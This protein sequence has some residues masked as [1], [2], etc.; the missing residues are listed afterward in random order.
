MHGDPKIF[1]YCK[2]LKAKFYKT[3]HV[4][5]NDEGP[6]S[7]YI[8]PSMLASTFETKKPTIPYL[9]KI[10]AI[11]QDHGYGVYN[12]PTDKHILGELP[13]SPKSYGMPKFIPS[14]SHTFM[15]APT[16]FKRW[17]DLSQEDIEVDNASRWLYQED[18]PTPNLSL[19]D[20]SKGLQIMLKHGYN[21]NEKLGKNDNGLLEPFIP[22]MWPKYLGL[23]LTT[24][25]VTIRGQGTLVK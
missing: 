4:S 3:S 25:K 11:I 21:K 13:Q 15:V 2:N 9:S 7:T 18:R 24:S 10:K 1:F 20:N 19:D 12:M 17:G 5:K 14:T 8:D 16:T 22:E 6:S 23:G